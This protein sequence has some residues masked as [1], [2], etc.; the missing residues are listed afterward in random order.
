VLAL[1]A[2]GATL[3]RFPRW[4]RRGAPE[5]HVVPVPT[6]TV[7]WQ[8]VLAAAG[9]R[10]RELG[11]H[12]GSLAADLSNQLVRYAL[13]PWAAGLGRDDAL[14]YARDR[15][16]ATYGPA[17]ANWSIGID[18]KVQGDGSRLVAAIDFELLAALRSEA[19]LCGLRLASVRPE[20]VADMALYQDM[21]T[22]NTGWF[23]Q[24]EPGRVCLLAFAAGAWQSVGNLRTGE[25]EL[26]ALIAQDAVAFGLERA[27][28]VV[29]L[30]GIPGAAAS[31]REHG[32][33]VRGLDGRAA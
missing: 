30:R 26:P 33:T 6:G 13:L 11:W 21:I 29:Y 19:A 2:G 7:G 10:L 9:V 4:P 3:G 32:W 27:E 31:L 22:A 16:A 1:S 25:A 20:L 8:P 15:M 24:A 18:A 17:A 12:G 23:V 5:W 14:A 28:A